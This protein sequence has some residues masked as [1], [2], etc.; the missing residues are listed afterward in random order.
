MFNLDRQI[1]SASLTHYYRLRFLSLILILHFNVAFPDG[2]G[3]AGTRI[4]PF[5]ILLELRVM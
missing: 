1:E 4:S 5:Q 2:P 3:L